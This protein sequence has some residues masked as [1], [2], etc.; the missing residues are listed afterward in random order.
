VPEGAQGRDAAEGGGE[1]RRGRKRDPTMGGRHGRGFVGGRS[2]GGQLPGT[3][4]MRETVAYATIAGGALGTGGCD[5]RRGW[6]GGKHWSSAAAD[7]LEWR[8]PRLV[9]D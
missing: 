3:G 4:D 9:V 8:C 1:G 2:T 6:G 7:L 5:G